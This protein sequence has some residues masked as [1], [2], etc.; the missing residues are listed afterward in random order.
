MEM[1]KDLLVLMS[2]ELR[3][4]GI[5]TYYY[6]LAKLASSCGSKVVLWINKKG[7]IDKEFFHL[8][9][10]PNIVILRGLNV[11]SLFKI[12]TIVKQNDIKTVRLVS[13]NFLRYVVSELM[14]IYFKRC[15]VNTFLFIPHF[16]SKGL[17]F[18]EQYNGKSKQKIL[19]RTKGLYSKMFHNGNLKFFDKKHIETINQKYGL[20]IETSNQFLVP[21]SRN[22]KCSFDAK[23]REKVWENENFKMIAVSRFEF[24]HKGY[25][26]GLIRS[27]AKLKCVYEK[28]QLDIVGYG[29][30]ENDIKVE[31]SKL[32]LNAQ[33]DISLLGKK[34]IDELRDL[35]LNYNLNISVAGCYNIGVAQGVLSLPARHYT[36]DC[37]VYGFSPEANSF[38]LSTEPAES[39]E[40]YI[41][42]AINMSKETYV[43]YCKRS[44]ES[45]NNFID[46]INYFEMNN[47]NKHNTLSIIDM[48]FCVFNHF[49]SKYIK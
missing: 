13:C 21:M 32:S 19:N 16:Q 35:Y 45:Q 44:F 41:E 1:K 38:S 39:V 40:K 18:E 33:K 43:D 2:G 7:F 10:C 26:I 37:E 47:K 22:Y 15:S 27:Y 4:G 49:R 46:R 8:Y 14:K 28:L 20:V 12:K 34:S 23:Q 3:V 11:T 25:I 36:Y 48:L 9:Q 31:I 30:G 17:F 24:P 5:E 29:L 6:N 42:L